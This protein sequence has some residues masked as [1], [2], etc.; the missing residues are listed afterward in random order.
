MAQ[1]HSQE[2]E[3]PHNIVLEQQILGAIL[4]QNDDYWKVRDHLSASDFYDHLH[5]WFFERFEADIT[6]NV[7]VSPVTLDPEIGNDPLFE[8]AEINCRTYMARLCANRSLTADI[9]DI[10]KAVKELSVRRALIQASDEAKE[11]SQDLGLDLAEVID[12]S[13]GSLFSASRNR[14]VRD[15]VGIGAASRM[16][17]EAAAEAYREGGKLAGLSTGLVG[18]DSLTGPLMPGDLIVLGGAT[19]AGKTALGQQ[20]A[21]NA[22]E[23]SSSVLFISIEMMERDLGARQIAQMTGIPTNRLEIGDFTEDEFRLIDEAAR[24]NEKIPMEIWAPDKN[25]TVAAIR[26]RAIRSNSVKP[27]AFLVIDHLQFI[28]FADQRDTVNDGISQITRD[29]K[30]LAK[31]LEIP[32]LLIS[33]LNRNLQGRENKRPQLSDLHGSSAIE[34]D[35]D[36]VFF[37]HRE[38]YFL[39]RS[40]PTEN[41]LEWEKWANVL[42]AVKGKAE[43]ILAKRRRGSGAGRRLLEFNGP[44]TKF[45]D[46]KFSSQPLDTR[47]FDG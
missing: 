42:T 38:E 12:R 47:I 7:Y 23:R 36:I 20:I 10:S 1:Q 43:V 37:I 14:S 35:A 27:L 29:I 21:I 34:K 40:E 22:A 32:I 4:C 24:N 31:E 28:Q 3:L 30:A 19:S 18:V 13:E 25:P 39:Q 8:S 11:M 15:V 26:S 41:T 5:R 6:K 44:L 33:H 2:K 45:S 46:A 9:V 16:A 17:A